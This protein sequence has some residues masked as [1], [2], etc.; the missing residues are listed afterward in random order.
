MNRTRRILLIFEWPWL[1]H[2]IIAMAADDITN[3]FRAIHDSS[4][5]LCS[6]KSFM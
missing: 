6:N 1:G 2:V 5:H 3:G 4:G